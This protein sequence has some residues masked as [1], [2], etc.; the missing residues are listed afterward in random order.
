MVQKSNVPSTRYCYLEFLIYLQKKCPEY[1]GQLF[2]FL[3]DLVKKL[4][5]LP[6]NIIHGKQLKTFKKS[7][8]KSIYQ[9][10]SLQIEAPVFHHVQEEV[11]ALNGKL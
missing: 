8:P 10:N 9:R 7:T 11:P 6:A 3:Q 1:Y 2:D 5:H 4:I